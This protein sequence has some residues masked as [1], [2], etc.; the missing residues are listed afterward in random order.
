M[1]PALSSSNAILLLF[2]RVLSFSLGRVVDLVVS[3]FQA[4]IDRSK[5]LQSFVTVGYMHT[6]HVARPFSP[7]VYT[8]V[9]SFK[10]AQVDRLEIVVSEQLDAPRSGTSFEQGVPQAFSRPVQHTA[11]RR[12]PKQARTCIEPAKYYD[13]TYAS[14]S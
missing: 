10:D 1:Q 3:L 11:G 14:S 12:Y 7:R 4:R 8:F 6:V 5:V 9:L 2:P 13:E